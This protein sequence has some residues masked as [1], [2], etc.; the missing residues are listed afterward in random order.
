MS[1]SV[2]RNRVVPAAVT[3]AAALVF[4]GLWAGAS[5]AAVSVPWV[6]QVGDSGESLG[7]GVSA[8][9]DGSSIVTGYF[10]GVATFGSTTLTSAGS[11]DV[12]VAKLDSDGEYVWVTQAGGSST[13][14]ARA[15]STLS[16]GSSIVTGQFQ[17][18]VT[19][20]STTLTSTGG[21]YD[22]DVFVAKL[23]S[24][25]NF[26]WA[27]SA[28]GGDLDTGHS[29]SVLS[30]GSSIVT[31]SY[32]Q[33]ATFGSTT[34]PNE[35]S[36][37]GFVAKFDA[38]GEYVWA[39]AVGG[40]GYKESWGV[41]T[42]SDGSS[43]VTGTFQGTATFGSLSVTSSGSSDAF[44]AKL[45]TDGN[46]LWVTSE[47]GNSYARGN[48]IRTLSDGSSIVTGWFGGTAIFGSTT[49]TS[50]GE[51]DV[52]VAKL[53]S[54]G[55]YVWATQAG[56]GA[57]DNGYG[58]SALSDGSSFVTGHFRGTAAFGSTTLTSTGGADD[59]DVFVAKVDPDGKFVWA[60]SAGGDG[61]DWGYDVSTLSDGSPLVTGSFRDT[62]TFGSTTL[63]SAGSS[64]AYFAKF[65]PASAPAPPA[66]APGDDPAPA[67]GNDPAPAPAAPAPGGDPAPVTQPQPGAVLLPPAVPPNV[68]KA[69]AK[70]KK[71]L[72][73]GT[74]N[75]KSLRLRL[76]LSGDADAQPTKVQWRFK[77]LGA[78]KTRAKGWASWRS[79]AV[80]P[81]A[82]KVR[83]DLSDAKKVRKSLTGPT[84][85][86]AAVKVQVR[87]TN[88]AGTSKAA[89]VRLKP[90]AAVP[91]LPANG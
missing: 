60:T 75:A 62:A 27:K 67:P 42:A 9:P 79:V 15:V 78:D 5:L 35:G 17:G 31:G 80:E 28:G 77:V 76:R 83:L 58:L 57:Y 30:D 51:S 71:K 16:D 61:D 64:D 81:Q 49:L 46:Y 85:N 3:I 68:G 21:A 2:R 91:M 8:L 11:W 89:S 26:V 24:D 4:T 47:G 41:S 34:L 13:D 87:A 25:G 6:T 84:H 7:E 19:F 29:V 73:T 18:T 52:F 65:A 56:G 66:P 90:P 36:W 88:D 69:L 48:G 74:G 63:T 86:D 44:V 33:G 43:F 10:E 72:A 22:Y 55:N 32:T 1:L 50:A 37:N 45:D 54:D 14:A 59:W 20:G 39:K 23:D 82:K 38:A 12:F 70:L 53:D 40:S